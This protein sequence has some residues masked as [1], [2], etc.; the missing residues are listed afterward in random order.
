[1]CDRNNVVVF[2]LQNQF[3][4]LINLAIRW[5]EI[6]NFKF[7]EKINLSQTLKHSL[8][9]TGNLHI[10]LVKQMGSHRKYL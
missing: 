2:E 5:I 4:E 3:R 7:C 1:M 8:V 9:G 10:V 6:K